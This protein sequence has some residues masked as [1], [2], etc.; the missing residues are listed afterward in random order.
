M[1]SVSN[2]AA[3]TLD[4]G[5]LQAFRAGLQGPLLSP[6]DAE[7]EA[8]R[9]VWNAMI[10]RKPALIARCTGTA[11]IVVAV[12]FARAHGLLL[13][14]HGGGHSVAGNAVC[15]GG[16]MIDLSLMKAIEVDPTARIARAQGGVLW[17]EFDAATQAH[18]LATT[19][20]AV[21]TTGIAGLTLGGG[22]GFL[23]RRFG[24][25]CDNVLEVEI[26]TA[27]GRVRTANE[28]EHA[29]LFWGIR[30]GGGNFGVA[31]AFTYQLHPVGPTVL[32]GL[33]LHP[34]ERAREALQFYRDF[35]PGAPDEL[36]I[37]PG[38]ITAA[39]GSRVI[40]LIACYAGDLEEGERVLEPLRRF[41]EPLADLI[42]P[43]PYT[44]LQ[45]LFDEAYPY[46]RRNYW[47]TSFMDEISDQAID[48]MLAWF[49]TVPSPYSAIEIE[50]FGGATGRVDEQA[51]AFGH[52]GSAYNLVVTCGWT[53]PAE[54]ELQIEWA[55]GLW[56]AMQPFSRDVGY[57]NYFS[58]DEQD[59]VKAAYGAKHERLVA[60]KTTYDPT[61]LFRVNQNI[62]PAG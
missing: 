9:G 17:S 50:Q 43:M 2:P 45:Q 14:V 5:A 48:T 41:G 33:V 52:R 24:L 54:D 25:A 16:L 56:R 28:T 31:T 44:S 49:E 18:G 46:G 7:Y 62:Q 27:D 34:L 10:D 60:L 26:V 20:G 22:W 38:I 47:K 8:A 6:G 59:R 32:G 37:I 19:G 55:R 36:T 13:A 15:D 1:T 58:V 53:D 35:C 4:A 39:D 61:N 23:L 3:P 11:D 40:A 42:A 21:S 30:G 57:V 29:D 51:T 12:N